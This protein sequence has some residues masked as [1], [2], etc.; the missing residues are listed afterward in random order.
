MPLEEYVANLRAV[1]GHLR[2]LQ[3]A[4]ALVIVTPPPI[5]EP[6]RII[7]VEKVGAK[8]LVLFAVVTDND[9]M[10]MVG[11]TVELNHSC[12]A[13]PLAPPPPPLLPP[14]TYG[15]RLEVS[16]RTN[17]AAGRY[18]AAAEALATELGL[19]CL[20]LWAALQGVP[21][22]QHGLLEDG[23]HLTP[24]GNAEVHRLLVALIEEHYPALR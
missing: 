17:E 23:L 21:G 19:P 18:A 24:A 2:R 13:A 20:N 5:S 6:D 15:T 4:P 16:E 1:V 8:R 10:Q 7:H 9:L 11:L 22:W 3:P 14:Q 12:A